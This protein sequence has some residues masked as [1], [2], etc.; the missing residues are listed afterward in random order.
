M[1]AARVLAIGLA[2]T[3]LATASPAQAAEPTTMETATAITSPTTVVR[4]EAID[5]SPSAPAASGDSNN[6]VARTCNSGAAIYSTRWWKFTPTAATTVVARSQVS[7]L[8]GRDEWPVMNGVAL[9]SASGSIIDCNIEAGV[10]QSDPQTV[11]DGVSLYVVQFLTQWPGCE[12]LMPFICYEWRRDFALK[13]TTGVRPANDDWQSAT[14]ITS[15]P[16][17]QSGDTT[18]ATSQPQDRA[19]AMSAECDAP[20]GG[21][22]NDIVRTVW[23]SYTPTSPAALVLTLDGVVVDRQ[24]GTRLLIAR[25][26]P[27][28]PDFSA[29]CTDAY[30]PVLQAGVTY[31]LQLGTPV[32]TYN[33]DDIEA[34]GPFTVSAA[35]ATTPAAPMGLTMSSAAPG[36]ATISWSPPPGDAGAPVTGYLVGRDGTDSGGGGPWS[37]SLP[38]SARSQTF[39]LLRP[40]TTYTLSVRA[41]NVVGAGPPASVQVGMPPAT[42][43]TEVATVVPVAPTVVVP[44]LTSPVSPSPPAAS[45]A[46][47]VAPP[48]AALVRPPVNRTLRIVKVQYDAPGR[49][50]ARNLNGEYVRLKNIGSRPVVLSGWTIRDA[51]GWTYTFRATRLRPGASMTLFTGKGGATTT[52]RYWNRTSHIWN[53]SGKESARLRDS[54]G[55]SIDSCSWTSRRLGY[56]AC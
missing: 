5:R 43:A 14:P 13:P 19:G 20:A 54:Y 23:W 40:D 44:Q 18:M 2:L 29:Y 38:A 27:Q 46:T 33:Y 49:D 12:E 34:G 16:Y 8:H 31:L 35:A 22:Y 41:I 37:T 25:L 3:T 47:V 51:R 55:R 1:S 17:T 36:T 15:L 28:G 48:P 24:P 56:V 26:T 11:S 21:G 7:S 50:N 42:A 4:G 9:V 6:A 32:R 30:P 52:R 10:T 39:T 45:T 53:N